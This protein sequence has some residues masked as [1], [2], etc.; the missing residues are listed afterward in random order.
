MRNVIL[1]LIIFSLQACFVMINENGFRALNESEHQN[2]KAFN[3]NLITQQLNHSDSLFLYE[4]NSIDIK[5][6]ATQSE[7]LWVHLWRPY[8]QAEY[9]QDIGFFSSLAAKYK[10]KGLTL[11]MISEVYDRQPIKNC[12]TNSEFNH[13]IF[14]LEDQYFGHNLRENR[15]R[16]AKELSGSQKKLKYGF[17]E[18]IFKDSSFIYRGNEMSQHLLD[19]LIH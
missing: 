7:Y 16:L 5:K 1:V 3:P 10:N 8:C 11:I 2:I 12:L 14:V 17:D 6:Y 4:I 19:S 15:I 18:F 13:P 9:C